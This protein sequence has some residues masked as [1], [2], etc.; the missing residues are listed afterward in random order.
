LTRADELIAAEEA[1]RNPALHT[2]GAPGGYALRGASTLLDAEGNVVQQW[3]KTARDRSP[4]DIVAEVRA[5]LKAKPIRARGRIAAPRGC[6]KD[7]L[8]VY[9][10][11]DPHIGMLSW[12]AETGSDFDLRIA[13]RELCAAVDALVDLA[14]P[15][16]Q[17][18]IANLGDFF[19]ADS[20]A[21]T[22]TGGTRMDMDS[23]WSKV[24]RA[25]VALLV[26]C[27][28]RALQKH[29]QVRVVCEIGNHDTNAAMM[30]AI[31]L[32][33]HYRSNPRV[34]I[35]TG[36]GKFHWLEFG[37]CLLGV[38]HGDT[39]KLPALPGIMATDQAA[40]WGRTQH[41]YW[42]TGHI[43]TQKVFEYPGCVVES[44]CTL[45]PRD[46]WN[47]GQGYRSRQSMVCD[48]LHREHGR[49]LRHEIGIEQLRG[50]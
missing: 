14:P 46:A 30:L 45:A 39:V 27:I 50:R 40:A 10:M 6:S 26:R 48:V 41:R 5:A 47:N 33:H 1:R 2:H 18:L 16:A 20:Q 24:F 17:A 15:A 12:H 32:D 22:T 7:R 11:G 23:R 3:V 43:H 8:V 25:G 44:F 9:P 29:G 34:E 36:P 31:C 28:D 21:G 13:E 37:K 49:V 35:D 38:T 19:H 4:A 42:Y